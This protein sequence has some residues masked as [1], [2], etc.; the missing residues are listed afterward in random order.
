[1]NRIVLQ[2][3]YRCFPMWI[4][5]EKGE[6]IENDLAPELQNDKSIESLLDNIQAQFDALFLDTAAEFTYLGF[7]DQEKKQ[8]FIAQVHQAEN[9][10]KDK[11]DGQYK[12]V[13]LIDVDQ[14]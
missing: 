8:K 7:K 9:L 1:M 12:V 11:L 5:N 3:E 10:I 6:V 14:L 13:N 2:M 4:Y